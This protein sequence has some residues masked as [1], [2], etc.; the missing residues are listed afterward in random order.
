[1]SDPSVPPSP[2]PRRDTRSGGRTLL[3][4]AVAAIGMA[5]ALNGVWN[6][7]AP[8][9][10]SRELATLGTLLLVLLFVGSALLGRRLRIS[11]IVRGVLGWAMIFAVLVGAYA[12]RGEIAVVGG[13]MLAAFSPG[14]PLP[15][16]VVG[17][18]DAASV[19]VMRSRRGQFAVRARVEDVPVTMLVDTGASFVTLT[20]VD[21]TGVGI[22]PRSLA[23]NVPIRTANGVIRAAPVTIRKL[24]V[25]SIVRQNLRA[26]VTPPDTLTESLLGMSFLE[27]LGG[28]SVSGDRLVLND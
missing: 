9:E 22:D 19:V 5:L 11:E 14:V 28:F 15:G 2:P 8:P 7:S 4:L 26:L 12:Y 1:M 10:E 13:R 6:P 20:L 24:E 17:E 21:A 27:T 25:G 18:D 23:F 3:V 16:R